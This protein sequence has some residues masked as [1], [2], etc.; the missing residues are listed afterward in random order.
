MVSYLDEGA[1]RAARGE[2]RGQRR[3]RSAPSAGRSAARAV[4]AR[5]ASGAALHAPYRG[6][7]WIGWAQGRV[8]GM[9]AST[10]CF[11]KPKASWR[12]LRSGHPLTRRAATTTTQGVAD[13]TSMRVPVAG[14][15]FMPGFWL[16]NVPAWEEEG[17][18]RC[19]DFLRI[20]LEKIECNLSLSL[21]H[22]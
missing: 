8:L 9:L 14:R 6:R 2:G 4:R 20:I 13:V 3:S 22:C 16:Q 19:C 1:A 15:Y 7:L 21:R 5:R 12:H 11:G 10:C 18:D 17:K